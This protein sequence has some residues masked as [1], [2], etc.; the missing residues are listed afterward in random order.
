VSNYYLDASA[1]VKRYNPETGEILS[2]VVDGD[3]GGDRWSLC[4]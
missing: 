2:N 4:E 1:V 3:I